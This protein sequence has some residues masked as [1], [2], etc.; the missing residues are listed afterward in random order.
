MAQPAHCIL[1]IFGLQC[2][3]LFLLASREAGAA[4]LQEHQ[5]TREHPTSDHFSS[6][7]QGP[8]SINRSDHI[9][10]HSEHSSP[11]HSNST[12]T[13]KRKHQCS[14]THHSKLLHQDVDN[15]QSSAT[16]DAPPTSEQNPSNQGKDPITRNKHNINTNDSTNKDEE[17]VHKKHPIPAPKS[18]TT[19]LK[20]TTKRPTVTSNPAKTVAPCLK[21]TTKRPTV[22][23]NPAKTTTSGHERTTGTPE[24]PTGHG[25]KTTSGHERTTGTPDTPIGHGGKTTSGHERTTGTLDTP[26]GHGGKTTSIHEGSTGTSAKPTGHEGKTKWTHYKNS[27]APTE[28]TRHQG[29]TALATETIKPP[30]KHTENSTK[31]TA[32]TESIR[33]PVKVTGD[34]SISTTSPCPQKPEVSRHVSVGSSTATRSIMSEAPD[35]SHPHQNKAGS[36]G[37]FHAGE[38]GEN[39]SFPAWAIVI[40][41]LLIVILLLVFLGL[42]F[43]VSYLARTRRA[44]IQNTEDNDPEDDGGPISYP[45]HLMEQQTLGM[46]QISSPQ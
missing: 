44:L 41:V 20:R 8:V 23:S 12:E 26:T 24:T 45:V 42:I 38:R 3:F 35:K 14:T 4:T 43:L 40:V 7:A 21:R 34:T 2:C 25:G 36:Q 32:A 22:T 13:H 28:S 33:P 31:V 19:C 6:L 18:K 11:D 9:A 30:I 37:D 16:Q 46:T 27:G 15:S 39:D 1:S 29:K 10:L 17:L 5:K